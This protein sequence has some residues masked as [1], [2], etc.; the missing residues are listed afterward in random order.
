[1]SK[2]SLFWFRRDLRLEDNRGLFSALEAGFPVLPLFI[3]DSN[4]LNNLS[5]KADA[6]VSFIYNQVESL[7]E[8]IEKL[9]GRFYVDYGDPFKII[10][11]ITNELPIKN[12]FT[13][14]DYE[15]YA[16]QRDHSIKDFLEARNITFH[17]SKDH[18]IFEERE[19]LSKSAGTPYTVF[20]PYSKTWKEKLKSEMLEGKNSPL[21][22]YNSEGLLQGNLSSNVAVPDFP[23]LEFMNFQPSKM[24]IPSREIN[25]KIIENYSENRDYPA[26]VGTSRLGIHLRFGTI[27]IR[28]LARKILNLNE[29][30]L[31]ELI[32]RDFYAQILFNFPHVE[33]NAFRSNYDLIKWRNNLEDFKK[34]A[35]GQTGFPLVDAGMRELNA[36]GFMHNR[37]RMLTASFLTKNLLID[38]RWGEKYFADKLLDFDLAS[39]NGGWQW[40]AG[41]G[42]DA[43]PYFRIFSPEAQML[44][45]DSQYQY[46][47]R[48]VPEFGTPHYVKP[49]IDSKLSKDLCLAAYNLALKGNS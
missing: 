33:K 47:K 38:W 28:E 36:T 2:I 43:A 13:N 16:L 48:W 37:V 10:E 26:K 22:A 6:R 7:K 5:D 30:F 40:A 8:K 18:V 39:N 17:L 19:I 9:G 27:G 32:W 1:M 29:T 4:I 34:W 35:S 41:S 3:F 14:K 21:F 49:M 23:L 46:I 42:T 25:L 15:S 44:K 12:V 31:N 24:D 45:F 20:T 11:R